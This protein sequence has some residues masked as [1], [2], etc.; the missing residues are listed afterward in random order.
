MTV[1]ILRRQR[2][3]LRLSPLS[4]LGRLLVAGVAAGLFWYGLMAAL[5]A[6]KVA[7]VT[8]DDISG[9]RTAFDWLA[10]IRAGDVTSQVRLLS[11][12]AG[13]GAAAV[14]GLLYAAHVSRAPRTRR[15]VLLDGTD[16]GWSVVRP[17]A[18]ER[19]AE[20]AALCDPAVG[21]A[22]ARSGLE[23]I[24]LAIGAIGQV[25]PRDLLQ[26][27]GIAV[28]EALARHELPAVAVHV[29]L[30]GARRGPRAV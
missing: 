30:A 20:S 1:S 5:L 28:E 2:V 12:L 10:G 27:V 6:A 22:S 13:S 21:E 7:P 23:R 11:G 29:T 25:D 8:V 15:P 17:R 3:H 16:H 18:I 26:R 24:D 4:L 9:Y 19:A 14:L